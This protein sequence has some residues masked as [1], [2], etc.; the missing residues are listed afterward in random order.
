MRKQAKM[1]L[2]EQPVLVHPLPVPVQVT[3]CTTCTGTPLTCTGIGYP[4]HPCT[5]TA[6]LVPVHPTGFCPEIF[7]F[8][9]FTHFSSTNHLQF[10]PYQK[11][12]MES[13]QN[14]SKCGLESMK[15]LFSQV[16]AFPPKSKSKYEIR[17]LIFLTL[18]LNLFLYVV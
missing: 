15:T 5:G 16:R 3:H 14:N 4:L 7:D 17:V 8:G 1:G 9:V 6:Q 2:L 13:T 11:S 12:T 18:N 10:V